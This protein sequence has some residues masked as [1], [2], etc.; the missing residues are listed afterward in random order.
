MTTNNP[1]QVLADLDDIRRSL[2]GRDTVPVEQAERLLDAVAA[3]IDFP[4][5]T[6][7]LVSRDYVSRWLMSTVAPAIARAAKASRR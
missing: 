7:D 6:R 4:A 1:S 2:A 3:A 5:L